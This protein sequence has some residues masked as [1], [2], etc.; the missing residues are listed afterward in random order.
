MS[1]L[2]TSVNNAGSPQP[3]S[4]DPELQLTPQPNLIAMMFAYRKTIAEREG[5][6][7]RRS[8]SRNLQPNT[9]PIA[10][11]TQGPQPQTLQFN[12]FDTPIQNYAMSVYVDLFNLRTNQLPL[13]AEAGKRIMI[14]LLQAEDTIG[15]NSLAFSTTQY[16]CVQGANG[17]DPTEIGYN[18]SLTLYNTLLIDN[19]MPTFETELGSTRI[20]SSAVQNSFWSLNSTALVSSLR[21]NSQFLPVERYS[22]DVYTKE[23]IGSMGGL[24]FLSS[25]L[26]PVFPKLSSSG[27]PIFVSAFG[28]AQAYTDVHLEGADKTVDWLPAN[29]TGNNMQQVLFTGRNIFGTAITQSTWVGSFLSTAS[30]TPVT[31]AA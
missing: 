28:G 5:T 10:P 8:Q 26:A 16:K 19:A 9:T 24:R 13:A 22:Q 17:Q 11:G 18:D 3:Y 12:V 29:Y 27:A 23:E 25:N 30:I 4:L 14:A 21:A 15:W 2:I 31:V 20:G 6:I 7:F 1:S